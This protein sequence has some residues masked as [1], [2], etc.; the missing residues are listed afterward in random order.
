MPACLLFCY[1][2]LFS[3]CLHC[4]VCCLFLLIILPRN[5]L[6]AIKRLKDNRPEWNV[7]EKPF[8]DA[9]HYCLAHEKRIAYNFIVLSVEHINDGG[10]NKWNLLLIIIIYSL[11][12][13]YSKTRAAYCCD[14]THSVTSMNLEIKTYVFALH[15]SNSSDEMYDVR[16]TMHIDSFIHAHNWT[17]SFHRQ[18]SIR[19]RC[20]NIV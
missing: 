12:E 2:L 17:N 7:R 10:A 4:I 1:S 9:V 5:K 14:S 15:F 3:F 13:W 8:G 19:E 20:E 16:C 6:D 18:L 11:R